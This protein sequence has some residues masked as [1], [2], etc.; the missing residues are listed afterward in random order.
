MIINKQTLNP[1]IMKSEISHYVVNG[2][3]FIDYMDAYEYC[4]KNRIDINKII[5]T[6][7]Y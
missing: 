3:L 2:H 5:K 4:F 7:E 1:K 6:K